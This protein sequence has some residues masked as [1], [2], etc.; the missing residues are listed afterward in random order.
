MTIRLLFVKP[1]FTSGGSYNE[2][3]SFKIVM[4][5]LLSEY[6]SKINEFGNVK[7]II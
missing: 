1:T 5:E 3:K 4:L 7:D 6:S 2:D